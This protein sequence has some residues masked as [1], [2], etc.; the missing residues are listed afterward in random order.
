MIAATAR[1]Y[2]P[3]EVMRLEDLPT[4]RPGPGQLLI[5]VQ[6]FGVTRGDARIRGLEAPRGMALPMR[7]VFGLTRPRRIIPGR[8]FAGTVE[9]LGPGVSGWQPGSAVLGITDGMTLG[10]GAQHLTISAQGLIA[11]RPDS[12]PPPQAAGFF[13][14]ALTAADFLIDQAKLTRGE[15]LLINGATGAVGL[16]ALQLARHI[17]A[18]TTAISSPPNH[19]LAKS[20]GAEQTADYRRPLPQGTW[21]VILDIAGTLPWAA[22]QPLLAPEGRLC[23]VTADLAALLGANL[24]P[25]RGSHRLC[26]G[27]VR[28]TPAAILRALSLHAQGALSPQ[29]TAL[30][31]TQIVEA[32]RLAS[33][34][35]KQGA[36]V[37]TL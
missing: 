19:A 1:R 15:R 5:R 8:E 13:F 18:R 14:G 27:M 10:A 4:P 30:P 36:V 25:K 29:I 9:A 3:P 26:A 37:V 20:L 28:E 12:L 23:L 6:A 22:A 2:G 32:H 21:D 17:G 34:G 33:S 7:L 31:L 11:R 35:H 16:A 24:R